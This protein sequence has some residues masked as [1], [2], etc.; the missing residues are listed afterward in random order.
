VAGLWSRRHRC[1]S[2]RGGLSLLL[3]DVTTLYF[4]AESE[5][6]LRKVRGHRERLAVVRAMGAGLTGRSS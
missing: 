1:L 2:N 6:E 3:Y 4:E 5:D